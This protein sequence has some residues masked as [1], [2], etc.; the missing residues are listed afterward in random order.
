MRRGAN[1]T[2]GAMDYLL[3][4]AMLELKADGFKSV[5]LGLSPLASIDTGNTTEASVD[6]ID[7]IRKL[8]FEHFTRIYNFQGLMKYKQKFKPRWE[9]RYLIY[10]SIPQLPKVIIALIKAHNPKKIKVSE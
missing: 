1:A 9:P 4:Q 6:L 8:V 7:R 5:S 2:K 3:I 10:P